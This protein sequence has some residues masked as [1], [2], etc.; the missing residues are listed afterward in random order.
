MKRQLSVYRALLV[1]DFQQAAQYRVQSVL[2]LLFAIIRPLVFL[3][4]WSAATA[5]QGGSVGGMS[6]PDFAAYYVAL[7]LATQLTMAW[8]AYE[9]ELEVR[10]GKLS[11]KLLRPLHPLHYAIVHNIVFK[12][13][14]LPALAPALFLMA[15]TFHAQFETSW[16]HVLLFV[17]C[18]LLA[19]ALRFM[20]GW[21]LA[22]LAFWTTR[23]HSIMHLY[24]RLSFVLAGQVAPLA[25]LPGPLAAIG[26]A[27][28]FGYTLWAPAEVLRGGTTV[29]QTI[30]LM[31]IQVAWLTVAV[32]AYL[33]VW[34]FGLRQYGAVGA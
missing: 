15:W 23:I 32:V 9:F 33:V 16:W 30:G 28:P 21:V 2:W 26:Y 31:G 27:L 24:D 3:S 34:R 14:T 6:G 18:V 4:A 19:A 17:P 8:D 11:P 12:V 20:L 1:A 29:E 25:L 22:T 5:A 13:V 7:T 10:Q